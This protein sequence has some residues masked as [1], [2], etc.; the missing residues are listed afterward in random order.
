[1]HFVIFSYE[2]Y[3][4][5]ENIVERCSTLFVDS[6]AERLEHRDCDR[7]GLCSKL[8][9]AIL[10]CPWER[11]FRHLLLLGGFGKQFIFHFIFKFILLTRK[12]AS[13]QEQ[14]P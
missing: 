1:M 5:V 13:K 14:M 12:K 7:H 3:R 9:C 6:L 10:L 8:T 2:G 11:H 4:M